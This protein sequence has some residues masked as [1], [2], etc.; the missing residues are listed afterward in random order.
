[1]FATT[2]GGR[3]GCKVSRRPCSARDAAEGVRYLDLSQIGS[4]LSFFSMERLILPYGNKLLR[5][6][7]LYV[8]L[9]F[10]KFVISSLTSC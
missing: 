1:M 6:P 10:G 3:V 7:K 4:D 5:Y 8:S 2:V 9:H